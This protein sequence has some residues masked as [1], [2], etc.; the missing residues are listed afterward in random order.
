MT[1]AAQEESR[2]NGQPTELYQLV[3]GG[4][5]FNYT[6]SVD[7]QTILGVPYTAV[8]VRRSSIL[9]GAEPRQDVL[10]LTLPT[11]IAPMDRYV[12]IVPGQKATLTIRRLHR[13]DGG[14]PQVVVIFK[15]TV[16]AVGYSNNGTTADLTVLPLTAGLAQQIPR[17]TYQGLCNHV[18]YDT[19]CKIDE[20]SYK[21]DGA[22]TVVSGNTLTIPGLNAQADGYYAGG[23]AQDGSLDFR[24]ILTHTGNDITLLLPFQQTVISKTLSVFAGCDHTIATCKTKFNNVVNYGGYAFVP[25]RNIFNTGLD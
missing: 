14:S 3:L 15:G 8:P 12:S 21:I 11:N 5:T 13:T 6:S 23:F 20:A 19:R 9:I 16:R 4:E 1:Y 22:V 18:L 10:T 2:E 24:M 7:D 17:F 25:L